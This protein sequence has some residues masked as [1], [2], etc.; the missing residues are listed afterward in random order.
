MS[1]V[2]FR[3]GVLR[4]RPVRS[5]IRFFCCLVL[6]LPASTPGQELHKL[7]LEYYESQLKE[8]PEFATREGR[9]EYNHLWKD[10]SRPA[11]DRQHRGFESYL[12]RLQQVSLTGL[13][14]QD[15]VSVRL[16]RYQLQQILEGEK[17]QT[18]LL[19]VSQLFALHND[20]YRTV[21]LMPSRT[22]KDHENIIA[23]LNAVPVY[24]D[25][26]LALLDEAIRRG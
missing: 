13:G 11:L 21:D 8:N 15:Q 23:R 9:G 25:Q 26:N 7:F 5:P 4:Y 17:L 3:V 10:W 6:F 18:Y 24:I 20:V 16:L 1:D 19:R 12:S 22:V 14:E 2:G